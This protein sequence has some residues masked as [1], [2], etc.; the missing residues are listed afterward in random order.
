MNNDVIIWCSECGKPYEGGSIEKLE[1]H[2]FHDPDHDKA[3]KN[4][5]EME[6]KLHK[7]DRLFHLLPFGIIGAV[8]TMF[9]VV[10]LLR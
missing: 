2:I 1:Q 4:R 7:D 10:I 8:L 3:L 5:I 9:G 6:R